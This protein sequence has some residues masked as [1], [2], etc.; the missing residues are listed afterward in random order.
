MQNRAFHSQHPTRNLSSINYRLNKKVLKKRTLNEDGYVKHDDFPDTLSF[1]PIADWSTDDVWGYL[2]RHRPLWDKD[3]AELFRLYTKASGDEC[4]F[5]TNL[6]Q[7][8]CGGSR[9]GCW[10]C[11]VVSEDKS[12]QGFINT[13]DTHLKPLN[14]FRNFLKAIREDSNARADYKRDGRA[15]HRVGGLGP[16]LS[17][18]RMEIFTRLLET[19]SSVGFELIS[20]SQILAIQREWDRDFDLKHNAIR[21]AHDFNRLKGVKM[22]KNKILHEEILDSVN[23]DVLSKNDLSDLISKSLEICKIYGS[24]G[25]NNANSRIKDE[26]KKLLKDKTQKLDSGLES[27]LDSNLDSNFLRHQDRK[28]VV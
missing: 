12:L 18:A 15:V 5:I 11:T 27:N 9:F 17:H 20:D 2:L 13:G 16:F 25:R 10:V 28:S 7:S 6:A 22:P 21:I 23:S 8:S 1:T 4:Q 26:I 24:R 14:D 19:E 3:H